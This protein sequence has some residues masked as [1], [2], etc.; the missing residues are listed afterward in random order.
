[1]AIVVLFGC[2]QNPNKN[3]IWLQVQHFHKEPTYGKFHSSPFY[4]VARRGETLQ[5]TRQRLVEAMHVKVRLGD[6]GCGMGLR[7]RGSMG[8][9]GFLCNDAQAALFPAGAHAAQSVSS[10]IKLVFVL[11][12]CSFSFYICVCWGRMLKAWLMY[13]CPPQPGDF[14]KWKLAVIGAGSVRYLENDGMRKG[15][16]TDAIK[17]IAK[18]VMC[19]KT[20]M[21]ACLVCINVSNVLAGL[22]GYS[23]PMRGNFKSALFQFAAAFQVQMTSFSTCWMAS[24]GTSGLTGQAD[25]PTKLTWTKAYRLG[26]DTPDGARRGKPLTNRSR[27]GNPV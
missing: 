9:R 11:L 12:C 27:Q 18:L 3:I 25:Q 16:V 5:D 2:L 10:R 19:H 26:T 23:G 21:H 6:T 22:A 4:F 20:R 8:T 7:A 1:V 24:R 17:V 14:G 13:R 15:W